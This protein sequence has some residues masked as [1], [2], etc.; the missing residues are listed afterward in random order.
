M[1]KKIFVA[2]KHCI[3]KIV[4]LQRKTNEKNKIMK[5]YYNKQAMQ[6]FINYVSDNME[7]NNMLSFTSEFRLAVFEYGFFLLNAPADQA[8]SLFAD[9]TFCHICINTDSQQIDNMKCILKNI[10][11]TG[12]K[13]Y[14]LHIN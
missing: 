14:N 11:A 3:E 2:N 13:K 7:D 8:S 4:F 1:K 10:I 5:S 12:L 9:L 6:S